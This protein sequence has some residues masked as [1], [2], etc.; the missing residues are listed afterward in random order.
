MSIL[1]SRSSNTWDG[2]GRGGKRRGLLDET[3][4]EDVRWDGME[5]FEMQLQSDC[6]AITK[7]YDCNARNAIRLQHNKIKTRYEYNSIA[8]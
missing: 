3:K 8:F 2:T 6:N 4:L 5:R 7:K 1:R